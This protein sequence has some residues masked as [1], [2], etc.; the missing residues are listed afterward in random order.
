MY[1]T[2]PVGISFGDPNEYAK[3][4]L[5]RQIQQL[6]LQQ[7]RFNYMKSQEDYKNAL[8]S[9]ARGEADRAKDARA[10]MDYK[11]ALAATATPGYRINPNLIAPGAASDAGTLGGDSYPD[12]QPTVVAP[13]PAD[14][15][16]ATDKLVQNGKIDAARK[17]MGLVNDINAMDKNTAEAD[18]AKIGV[19]K[20]NLD[21]TVKAMAFHASMLPSVTQDTYDAWRASTVKDV[22]H[23]DQILPPQAPADPQQ[24]EMLKQQ[25]MA[26]AGET[27]KMH[28]QTRNLGNRTDTIAINPLNN[29]ATSVPGS[30]GITRPQAASDVGKLIQERDA[31][32]PNSPNYAENKAIYD[33]R[34]AK[35]NNF[36]AS[37]GGT[38]GGAS[39]LGKLMSDR[40]DLD[41]KDPEYNAKRAAYDRAIQEATGG[42]A[43]DMKTADATIANAQQA[44]ND[45]DAI[46]NH[47][48]K[49]TY[50]GGGALNPGQ[51]IP[52][53]QGVDFRNRMEHAKGQAFLSA[54]DM[55]R[56]GGAIS[57]AEGNK[58]TAA[59]NRMNQSLSTK[60][61]DAAIKDAQ[62]IL[63]DGIERAKQM[64]EKGTFN[65][66]TNALS[67]P[68]ST[69]NILPMPQNNAPAAPSG[70]KV[71][72]FGDL[73]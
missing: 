3:N 28:Y 24:F 44:I 1:N 16:T 43:K 35:A 21:A 11:N 32:D 14:P 19:T 50:T 40:A 55:L 73:Q 18:K 51:Y 39:P 10:E 23:L 47:P 68:A 58:A 70:G 33:A 8:A 66:D 65:S 36:K 5:A 12:L 22:P 71:I 37:E 17:G 38:G 67:P 45:L 46:L 7:G 27:T 60:D 41:P 62:K 48:A 34:I 49:N 31:L 42:K 64:K 2:A 54:F 13:T 72:K 57:D 20:D 6:Q 52:G 61:F 59:I 29:Q 69:P 30:E 63:Q 53:S 56:G 4:A 26:K 9:R 25:L 15:R